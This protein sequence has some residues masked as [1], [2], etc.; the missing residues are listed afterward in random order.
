MWSPKATE[1]CTAYGQYMFKVLHLPWGFRILGKVTVFKSSSHF[2]PVIWES[3]AS[4]SELSFLLLF[5]LC[6]LYLLLVNAPYI[7]E[8]MSHIDG[9][10]LRREIGTAYSMSLASPTRLGQQVTSPAVSF[11]QHLPG[12]LH[13]LQ[14]C[15]LQSLLRAA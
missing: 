15:S 1:S 2:E 6:G 5:V 10:Y 12:E 8:C 13:I 4:L 11:L 9:P 14:R 3:L 7:F